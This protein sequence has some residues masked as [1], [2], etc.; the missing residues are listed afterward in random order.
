M[1]PF[2]N[3]LDDSA[4]KDVSKFSS[5]DKTVVLGAPGREK[6]RV[7]LRC[8]G[9]HEW[10]RQAGGTGPA[11][12]ANMTIQ[13]TTIDLEPSSRRTPRDILARLKLETAP[14]HSAIEATTGVMH[15]RLSPLGYRWYLERT[16][17]FYEPVEAQ[18]DRFGVWRALELDPSP[19]RKLALL[20]GDIVHLGD[21]PAALMLCKAPP[22]LANLAEAVGCAYVLEGSTLGGRVIARHVLSRLG[23]DVPRSFLECYGSNTGDRWQEFRAA[24]SRFAKSRSIEDDVIVGAKKTFG[25][26]T[27]WLEQA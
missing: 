11:S 5:L 6:G 9:L 26:F 23:P 27:R 24:L 1:Q 14:E 4:Q 3:G 7:V 18:L 25:A 19:R 12:T 15:P 21:D 17:G 2:P 10:A 20:M 22:E 13:A 8:E 16:Y